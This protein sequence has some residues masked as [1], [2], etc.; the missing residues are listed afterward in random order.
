MLMLQKIR[1]E[2]GMN[3]TELARKAEISI[4]NYSPIEKGR[5]EPYEPEAERLSK[6]LDVS[7][8]D[9]FTEVEDS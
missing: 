2:R 9:L 6:V 8:D 4:G 5:R 1:E 7:A 3:R